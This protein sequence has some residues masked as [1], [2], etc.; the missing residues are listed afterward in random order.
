MAL[1]RALAKH[2]DALVFTRPG[3]PTVAFTLKRV[4]AEWPDAEDN[5]DFP[6]VSI[7]AG[8]S[9]YDDSLLTPGFVEGTHGVFAP[10]TALVQLAE[11]TER[12]QLDVWAA[13]PEE[14]EAVVAGLESALNPRDGA[15][16]LDLPLE[17]YYNRMA[18][19]LLH[20]VEFIDGEESA[21]NVRRA[22]IRIDAIAP[23][24]ALRHVALMQP[25]IVIEAGVN[26]DVAARVEGG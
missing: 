24:V 3:I 19:Y 25:Q 12:I 11:L 5:I 9:L 23:V 10:G 20:G 17:D 6:S 7:L 26:M 13:T 2:I 16:G 21:T 8:E 18:S 14:R 1:T 22:I 15:Y 4:Y